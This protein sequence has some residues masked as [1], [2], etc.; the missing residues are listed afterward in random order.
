MHDDDDD[1]D[2]DGLSTSSRTYLIKLSIINLI[3][4][5]RIFRE[6]DKLIR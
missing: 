1:D 3:S 4:M 2:D 5:S 6:C